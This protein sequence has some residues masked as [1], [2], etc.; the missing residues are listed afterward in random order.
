MYKTPTLNNIIPYLYKPDE[1]IGVEVGTDVGQT[2]LE[3]GPHP[4]LMK[5]R[6]LSVRNMRLSTANRYSVYNLD[7][8]ANAVFEERI[9]CINIL[10][11]AYYRMVEHGELKTRGFI[12]QCL[13]QSLN[14]AEDAA[15]RGL[16]LSDWN[17]LEVVSCGWALPAER[18]MR[19]FF[20]LKERIKC[21][22]VDFNL[23]FFVVSLKIRQILAFIGAHEWARKTFEREFSKAGEGE[24]T[25]VEKIV[26]DES[27]NQVTFA[28]EALGKLEAV[29]VKV[30]TSHYACQIL[31]NRAAHYL[32]KLK[33][34]GLMTER[35]A[36]GFLDAIH[37]NI[38]DLFKYHKLDN[39]MSDQ[40]K[41][42]LLQLW[43]LVEIQPAEKDAGNIPASGIDEGY[44]ME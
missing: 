41:S 37:V 11:A 1:S 27:D 40:R 13:F 15:S 22:H 2:V 4:E 25:A 33:N 44:V 7:Y 18:I 9:I 42:E 36:G 6:R 3:Q 28:N 38:S 12:G 29:D 32:T 8:D 43:K 10:R 30:V 17:A 35:E 34:Y 5:N 24:L 19:N 23:D 26:L 16:P 14:Y 39:Q 20:N 21:K 31:L